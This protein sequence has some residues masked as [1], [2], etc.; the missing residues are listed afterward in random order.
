MA[1]KYEDLI[2]DANVLYKAYKA[3]VKGSKWKE[4]TQKFMLNFLSYIFELLD[5]L[6]TRTYENGPTDEFELH[7]RGRIRP[8]TSLCVSDRIIRHVLCDEVFLPEVR[9]KIIYDNGASIN[10]R[11]LAHSRKRFE[12][13]LRRYFKEYGNNGYILFGDFS[14]FYDNIVHEIAKRELLKLV[15]DDE[16]V[17][18]LLTLIFNGFRVDVSFMTDDEYS[19]CMT[20]CFNKLDYREIPKSELTGEKYMEKSVNIGDQLSQIIG[21]YYPYRIDNYVKYVRSQKY[22]GRYMDD[23]YIMN[24]SKEALAD[25]MDHIKIIASELGIHINDKKTRIVKIKG[26]YRYLQFRYELLDNGKIVVKINQ[27]RVTCMRQKLKKLAAK[28][29]RGE[30]KYEN[31]EGMFRGWMCEFYKYMSKE[32]RKNML[33]LYEDLFK[34][35]IRIIKKPNNKNKM[36]IEDRNDVQKEVSQYGSDNKEGHNASG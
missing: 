34:K 5:K 10:G 30:R 1:T 9:K 7:E 21:V 13:H 15:D 14:K 18:W 26:P 4:S 8:I 11:G 33:S 17:E 20:S 32:Q 12:V 19:K 35:T 31:I 3:S 22:Y 36:I 28:L 25:I 16:F 6:V 2:C 27:K 23:F 29:A 24:P